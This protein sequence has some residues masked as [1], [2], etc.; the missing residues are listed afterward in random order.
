MTAHATFAT[1]RWRAHFAR[2][3]WTALI[4]LAARA[5][6]VARGFVYVSIGLI[7][8]L[9]A[10]GRTP[11]AQGAL[12]AL[13]AWSDWPPGLVL[14]W[15]TGAG[16]YGFA[17]W[18][19]LQSLLDADR[20]GTSLKALAGRA[21]QALSGFV[22]AGLGVSVFGLLDALEDLHEADDQA[23]TRATVAQ[24]LALPLGPWLVIAAG[25]FILGLGVGNIVQAMT[26][27]FCKDLT[28]DRRV[29]GW[30]QPLGRAGYFARGVAFLPAGAFTLLAGW[31]ARSEEARGL[32]GALETLKLQP[33]GAWILGLTALGLIAFGGFAFVEA[34]YRAIRAEAA[35]AS[36]G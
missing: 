1:A 22:Y 33:F 35:I 32:G 17:G 11:R 2:S 12:G 7:G 16:L 20:K 5:G 21:G 31:H 29:A 34:R 3:P 14:L 19:A 30:A 15:L 26:R 23:R 4:E 25:L 28:C 13:E 8:V 10:L 18:R 27:D 36:V 6:Y 9:A 24:A